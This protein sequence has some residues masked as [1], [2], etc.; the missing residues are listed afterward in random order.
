M[1]SKI[2]WSGG[3]SIT[4]H[5]AMTVMHDWFN[6]MLPIVSTLKVDSKVTRSLGIAKKNSFLFQA[7][8]LNE[9]SKLQDL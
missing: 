4:E 8:I 5:I 7:A 1:L 6:N 3:S 9:N 2:L